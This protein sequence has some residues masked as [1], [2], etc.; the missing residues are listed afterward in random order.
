MDYSTDLLKEIE[1]N[2]MGMMTPREISFLLDIDEIQFIDDINTRGNPARKA[3]FR[4]VTKTAMELRENIIDA[5]MAGSPFSISECQKQLM[6]MLAE[7]TV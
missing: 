4:G 2:A 5:A 6:Q 1:K 3:F 7:I